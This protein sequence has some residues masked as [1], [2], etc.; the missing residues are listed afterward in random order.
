MQFTGERFIPTNELINDE[1]G[2]EHLHRYHS[3]IPFIQNK[4]VLD[5]ACGEGYGTALIG[6]YA[7]KAVG[8]DI[9]DTCIQWGTQHYA[10]ANNKLEFKK[11]T[12]DNIPL[13]DNSVDVV[14]SFETIEH[15]DAAIQQ[16]FMAEVKRV[17]HPDGILIISTPN[18]ANYSERYNLNNEFHKKEFEKEEFHEFLKAHFAY[19]YH[20]EQ[21]YEIVS[22]ITGSEIKDVHQL[23]VLN[24]ERNL[25][26]ANRK[27][28]ISIASNKEVQQTDRLSSVVL[29]VDKDFLGL[30]DY[31]VVLQK[32]EQ[33]LQ[34][35]IE[36]V[37]VLEQTIQQLQQTIQQQNE[38]NNQL[39]AALID[40]DN[41]I[42]DQNYRVTTVQQ[43]VDQLNGRLSEIY[44][45]DGWK[46]LSV[47]YRLKGKILPE[48]SGRYKKVKTLINKLRNKKA[49][50]FVV[51]DFTAAHTFEI[52]EITSFDKIEFPVFDQPKV[53]III[54]A[55]D[56]WQMNYRCLRSIFKNTHG[57]SYEVIF[58]D[59]GSSDETANITE[60]IK[61]VVLIRNPANLG[62]LKNCNNATK[63]AKGEYILFLNN[64]T[65]VTTGWL[66]SL[67]Q[68]MDKDHTIGITGSKLIYPDGRL[69]EA[70]GIFWQDASAWNYGHKR[71]PG[72]PEY[73]YVKEV[74][75]ISGASLMIRKSVWDKIGGFDERYSPAYCEDADLAFEV[76]KMGLKVVYQPLSVVIHHEGFSHGSDN[77]PKAG[78][79]T[80]KEYQKLNIL[81]FKSKWKDELKL[82]FPNSTNI[83]WARDRSQLKKTILVIDH[84]VPHFDKDAGSRTTFQ[85]LQLFTSL[86][87][88][89]KFIGDNFYKHEPYTTVLQQLGIEVLFGSHYAENWQKWIL[90]NEKYFDYILLNRPHISSKYI[91]F[92]RSNTKVKIYYYGHDLHFYRELKEYEITNDKKKLNSSREWKKIEYDL[93]KK[94]DVVLTPTLKEKNIIQADFTN[95]RIEV[96][97]AFFYPTIPAPIDNF[98]NRNDIMFVGG[99]AHGPNLNAVLWY[100]EKI[101]PLVLEKMPRTRLIVVGSNVPPQIQKLASA[102][103][104]IKGFVSDQELED[105]YK[106]VKLIVIPLRYGAG[107]KG[108]T[109]EAMVN[110]LPIVSTSF[111]LEGLQVEDWLQ[112]H[113]NEQDFAKEI[114]SLYNDREAL[115]KI[116]A[117]MNEYA[118]ENFTSEAAAITFKKIFNL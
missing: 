104:V 92:L 80:I 30:I 17:L 79:T 54:P 1:I 71:N 61:N 12:V 76:R 13:A 91:D 21:G 35:T 88:N 63:F 77:K 2:F 42:T 16:R 9:D 93:F 116:S 110:G 3:I 70:G 20:F 75:Y 118:R 27:Y 34:T 86:G 28:L 56:G 69:Q 26:K 8:V 23:T 31:I 43:Q 94:A 83:F 25:K 67:T 57:V 55:Y 101:H 62:F 109:V 82:Q 114:I 96:M 51:E 97:P 4:S 117:K 58:A 10:A 108:K 52:E 64:D 45:S 85:Y 36:Q 60:Y 112:P 74:D 33:Q 39:A 22:T 59:D 78:L 98:D 66:H 37:K 107:L 106:S 29:Q 90:E 5:I 47:Y 95:K 15:L 68:L 11:G 65:E 111:G 87:M 105:L 14:V 38:V 32:Q 6:K 72:A 102:S 40:K 19:A 7:Q 24:W 81:K 113:D 84:Y 89:V 73:T 99:F 53:S 100:I 44:S 46:L 50:S 49:D 103:I 48:N 115:K 18:T 41:V